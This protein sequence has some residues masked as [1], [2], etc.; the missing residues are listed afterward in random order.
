MNPIEA[1]KT[2]HR[3]IE[4]ALEILSEMFPRIQDLHGN[5]IVRDARRL[6]DFFRTF[7]DTCHHGKEER[8]L[9]PVLERIGVSRKGG[10]IGVMLSEHEEGRILLRQL[11]E[12]LGLVGAGDP[13]AGILFKT[14]AEAY[15]ELL[16]QHIFKEDTV[17]FQIAEDRLSTIRKST[18][19]D[20]FDRFEKEQIGTGTH[21]AFHQRLDELT[22]RYVDPE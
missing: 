20:Q 1:L 3:A 10:P 7:A 4:T 5:G 22:Q 6:L 13:S 21:E 16:R 19:A 15:I 8:F 12:A 11:E 18:L 17:L 14:A 9:F 2:E